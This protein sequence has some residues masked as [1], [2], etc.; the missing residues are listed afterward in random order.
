[1]P[2]I[3]T[4]NFPKWEAIQS[5]FKEFTERT[6]CVWVF[7]KARNTWI[8]KSWSLTLGKENLA[9]LPLMPTLS[10]ER[11]ETVSHPLFHRTAPPPRPQAHCPGPVQRG[12]P[13]ARPS[14]ASWGHMA[15]QKV[16]SG[17]G[18]EALNSA[19]TPSRWLKELVIQWGR[20]R[21]I[22]QW[23]P[24]WGVCS[25]GRGDWGRGVGVATNSDCGLWKGFAENGTSERTLKDKKNF[26]MVLNSSNKWQVQRKKNSISIWLWLKICFG[27]K[28]N[29][30]LWCL[31]WITTGN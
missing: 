18:L 14:T 2:K 11:K 1:M 15:R 4:P 3:N 21:P 16:P 29:N 17:T 5:N 9:N 30:N 8:H 13:G 10:Q 27:S 25:R 12:A 22:T 24:L 28:H 26:N 6:H 31:H 20:P 7:Q 23:A 19:F